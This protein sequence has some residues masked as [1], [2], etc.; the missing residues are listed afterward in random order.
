MAN[1]RDHDWRP[2]KDPGKA[3]CFHCALQMED[4]VSVADSEEEAMKILYGECPDVPAWNVGPME[5]NG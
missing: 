5:Q 1:K 3:V 2:R 4:V